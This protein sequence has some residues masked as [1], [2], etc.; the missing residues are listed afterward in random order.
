[1]S[2]TKHKL[3]VRISNQHERLSR[4]STQAETRQPI[5]HIKGNYKIYQF[6]YHHL[7]TSEIPSFHPFFDE[8][9]KNLTFNDLLRKIL[10]NKVAPKK[11]QHKEAA[12][13]I[14]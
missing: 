2:T 9:L 13:G 12:I 4:W 14:N 7:N 11:I 1:M 3:I 5:G 8:N 10:T 6:L